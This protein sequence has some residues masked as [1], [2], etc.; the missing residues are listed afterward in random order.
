MK[1]AADKGTYTAFTV[2]FFLA[3]GLSRISG[4]TAGCVRAV[5][6]AT[7]STDWEKDLCG[8]FHLS[9]SVLLPLIQLFE[10]RSGAL[11]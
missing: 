2:L 8:L 6:A 3:G 1:K 9:L 10:P 4:L 5:I 7:R 11:L